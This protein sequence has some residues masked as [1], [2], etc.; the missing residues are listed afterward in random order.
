M[1][2]PTRVILGRIA[3]RAHPEIRPLRP[4]GIHASSLT[5]VSRCARSRCQRSPSALTRG[6]RAPV[7]QCTNCSS[8]RGERGHSR[9]TLVSHASSRDT[10]SSTTSTKGAWLHRMRSCQSTKRA[11]NGEV[12]ESWSLRDSYQPL[13]EIPAGAPRIRGTPDDEIGG[14]QC[15]SG[16]CLRRQNS[17][18]PHVLGLGSTSTS[19]EVLSFPRMEP[20]HF[21]VHLFIYRDRK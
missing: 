9:E 2:S 3:Q 1:A 6:R 4:A 14:P 19:S 20:E 17:F 13:E 7:L 10:S 11:L 5:Y 8:S 12:P 21:M 15:M 16:R 18:V